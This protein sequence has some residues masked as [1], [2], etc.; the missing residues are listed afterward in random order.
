VNTEIQRLHTQAFGSV[1]GKKISLYTLA[2]QHGMQAAV[3]NYGATL[4]SLKT[5]DRRGKIDDIVLGYDDLPGYV[6]DKFYFGSTI[7]RYANR[8]AHGK[9]T[10]DGT[11]YHLACNNGPNHLHGGPGGFHKVV[12]EANPLPVTSDS[13]GVQFSYLSPDGEEGYP[14][15][16]TV[17][18]TYRVSDANELM[19][20]Y[21][22]S[23]DKD[24]IV[25][26]TNHSYF[27]LAGQ[28]RGDILRHQLTIHASTF[29]PVN[30]ALIPTGELRTL[31]GTPLDFSHPT[32]IGA[33][34]DNNDEQLRIAGGYDHNFVIARSA[35][36]LAHAAHVSEP[37]SGR[38]MDVYTSE[39]G[40]Q[41]YTGNFLDGSMNGKSG[42][43][44]PFRSGLTLE[45]Q[46]YPDSPNHPAFPRTALQ[47]GHHLASQ[48]VYGFTAR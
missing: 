31:A 25:N 46:H 15:N 16:L 23:T 19:I 32:S 45:T 9:F 35:R 48:T 10:L 29:T 33:R 37:D 44:Y 41:L 14:G 22:A 38:V 12:W 21:A 18:V 5:P 7:G 39:P 3:I 28:G 47:R 11:R 40:I 20:D 42:K 8:I 34:I 2:N 26:L 24:T 13:A 30:D 17:A 27:N 36:G 4:V 1:D 6:A 43:N